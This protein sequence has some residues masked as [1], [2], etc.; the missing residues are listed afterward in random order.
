MVKVVDLF[1]GA[2][3][4]SLGF[5]SAGCEVV[6]AFDNW[7]PAVTTYNANHVA[8]AQLVDVGDVENM[9]RILSAYDFDGIIG[10][11]PCQD[12]SHAGNRQEGA[13]ADLTERFA[14]LVSEV[15]PRFVVMENVPP[16]L[17]A[18]AYQN[19]LNTLRAAGYGLNIVTL[20]ASY[21]NVPQNRK[22]L[23]TVGLLGEPD[24]TL[25]EELE[26]KQT[27]KPMTVRDM[28]G[29]R[30]GVD[31]FYSHPRSYAR[32]GIFSIDEPSPTVRGQN[33]PMPATYQPHPGDAG[34]PQSS[35]PLTTLERAQLQTFPADYQ[36]IGSK[37]VAEQMVGNA[38]PVRLA[39]HVAQ[40]LKDSM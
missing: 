21:F 3:G 23:F 12:F 29:S 39:E 26:R 28:F 10:G 19:A 17:R 11:P 31:C 15:R 40:I 7:E 8:P 20:N 18:A 38:V 30:L 5:E 37:T 13:R 33:R 22:R 24:G 34:A 32:R 25:V 2:G 27:I 1:C 14:Q 9:A 4:L 36:W 16:A 35:R 6:A